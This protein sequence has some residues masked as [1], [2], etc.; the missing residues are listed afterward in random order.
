MDAN[1][2]WVT[3]QS[4]NFAQENLIET[5]NIIKQSYQTTVNCNGILYE[6]TNPTLLQQLYLLGA[7]SG[8]SPQSKA[9]IGHVL[10]STGQPT[11]GIPIDNFIR[12][13]LDR[14]F[15]FKGWYFVDTGA[16]GKRPYT[17]GE[18]IINFQNWVN[19]ASSTIPINITV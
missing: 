10:F 8:E 3:A 16:Y 9:Y 18:L 15:L 2:G 12:A 14:A 5:M 11:I 1:F 4:I 13:I 7:H 6:I 19:Q 17:K